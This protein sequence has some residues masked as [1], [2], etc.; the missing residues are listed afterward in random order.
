MG[1]VM[2]LVLN[3]YFENE[4][5]DSIRFELADSAIGYLRFEDVDSIRFEGTIEAGRPELSDCDIFEAVCRSCD[6]GEL[7]SITFDP[8][9]LLSWDVEAP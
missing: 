6:L 9:E 1:R 8:F 7:I 5:S 2:V 3:E 4:L